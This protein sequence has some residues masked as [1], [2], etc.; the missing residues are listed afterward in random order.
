VG[1]SL[2]RWS[3]VHPS[4]SAAT[5][6][7]NPGSMAARYRDHVGTTFTIDEVSHRVRLTSVVESPLHP[8]IEQFSLLFAGPAG[9]AIPHGIYTFRHAALGRLEMFITPVG[10]PSAAPVYQACFSRHLQPKDLLCR[11]SS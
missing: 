3:S 8:E 1:T 10:A 6:A 11:I 5:T 9:D 4:A 2:P 7:A